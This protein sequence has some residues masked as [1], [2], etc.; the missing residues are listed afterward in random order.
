MNIR[1]SIGMSILV[2][3]LV[4]MLALA[5]PGGSVA[6]QAPQPPAQKDPQAQ[7]A[8][9]NARLAKAFAALQKMVEKQAQH[10]TRAEALVGKVEGLISKAKENGKDTAAL[11]A[12][13]AAFK[14]KAAEAKKLNGSAA[15]IVK[16]H[17]G[18]DA[19]GKVVDREPARETLKAGNEPLKE[20][21]GIFTDALKNLREA[22][23]AWRDANP[24]PQK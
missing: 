18:F 1:K 15:N 23:K 6:A 5:F 7:T 2:V 13:V 22:V 17:A 10:M 12:A 14:S 16:I 24:K 4:G 21:R 20:A 3:L 8:R 19:D 11:E 9:I